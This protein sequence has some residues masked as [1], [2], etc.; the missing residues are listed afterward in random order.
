MIPRAH[1]Q[2]IFDLPKMRNDNGKDLRNLFEGI[3]EHRLFANIG[4]AGGTLRS[5]SRFPCK[6]TIRLRNSTTMGNCF[7]WYKL[8]NIWCTK[9]IHWDKMQCS[10]GVNAQSKRFYSGRK[11]PPQQSVQQ[12]SQSY[13]GT[14]SAENSLCCGWEHRLYTCP[15]YNALTIDKKT[16][17]IKAERLCFNCLRCGHRLQDCASAS[18]C[19]EWNRSLHESLHRQKDFKANSATVE[20]QKTDGIIVTSHGALSS[21][22][23]ILPTAVVQVQGKHDVVS[24]RALLDSGSQ[25]SFITDDASQKLVTETTQLSF[26]FRW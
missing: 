2:G 6:R 23:V 15:K 10:W 24:L 4:S 1:V 25:T 5:L 14:Q 19:K 17:F 18:K 26:R 22:Q 12:H 16:D 20:V 7:T 9:N 3:E 11:H 21:E 8:K 13:A